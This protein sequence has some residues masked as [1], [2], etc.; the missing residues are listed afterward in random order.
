MAERRK[1]G[2][3]VPLAFYDSPE[4]LSIP[5]RIRAEAVGVWTLCGSYSANQLTDGYVSAEKLKILGCR[6]AIRAA[7]MA[8]RD[9]EG[10]PSPLWIDTDLGG[11]RFTKWSKWQRTHDEVRNYR[12]ADAE[13]KRNERAAAKAPSS[14]NDGK[15]SAKRP[16]GHAPD[17]RPDYREPKTKTETEVSTYVSESATETL[18]LNSVAATPAADLVRR[19]IPREIN[20]ATQTALRIHAGTL[21]KDNPPDVVEE[22]LRD[23]ATRTGIGPGVLPSLAADVI[24]RRNGHA[25]AAP[26]TNGHDAKVAD[27]LAFANRPSRPEIEQ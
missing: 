14:C 21:L 19:T 23:W 12:A 4:V 27:F 15:S 5:K 17:V 8:T 16:S 3:L 24:K 13:R 7:L 6:P 18:G 10:A 25:R 22:A 2:F 20:S 11:I 1:A 26:S 9:A